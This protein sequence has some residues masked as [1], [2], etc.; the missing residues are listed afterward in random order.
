VAQ[1]SCEAEYYALNSA[2]REA[3]WIRSFMEEIGR[4]IDGPIALAY[5]NEGSCKLAYNPEYHQRTKHISVAHHYIRQEVANGHIE[6]TYLPTEQMPADGLTKALTPQKFKEFK[7]M[8]GMTDLA[9][10]G[11]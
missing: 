3:T 8:I 4:P 2:A 6:L 1:S 11:K 10:G 5:D 9:A 7:K